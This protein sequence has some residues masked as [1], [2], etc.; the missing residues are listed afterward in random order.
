MSKE[1]TSARR[2]NESS[3]NFLQASDGTLVIQMKGDWKIG[4]PLPSA[5]EVREEAEAGAR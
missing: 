3:L 5:D 1:T 2:L 4:N